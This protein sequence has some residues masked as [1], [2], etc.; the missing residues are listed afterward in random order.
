[1]E[2]EEDKKLKGKIKEKIF[3]ILK[4][5]LQGNHKQKILLKVIKLTLFLGVGFYY[6]SFLNLL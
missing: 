6:C 2:S 5:F 3:Q 4:Y 1:M